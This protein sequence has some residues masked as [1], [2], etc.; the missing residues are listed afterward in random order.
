MNSH[1]KYRIILINCKKNA[2]T[3]SQRLTPDFQR[4]IDQLNELHEMWMREEEVGFQRIGRTN[5]DNIDVGSDV[6]DETA[7]VAT[8]NFAVVPSSQLVNVNTD[9]VIDDQI[10]PS[11]LV[12][13][14]EDVLLDFDVL[15]AVQATPSCENQMIDS[16]VREILV[17]KVVEGRWV[18]RKEKTH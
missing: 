10:N 9:E 16:G 18:A 14:T 17:S 4:K 2:N 5:K 7:T 12:E 15:G 3:I 1:E 8:E 11:P 13:T 6:N